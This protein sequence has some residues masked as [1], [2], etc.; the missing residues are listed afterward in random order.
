M[1]AFIVISLAMLTNFVAVTYSPKTL[2]MTE[3]APSTLHLYPNRWMLLHAFGL[4]ACCSMTAS[5]LA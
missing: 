3:N 4:N 1:D 2:F 5:F